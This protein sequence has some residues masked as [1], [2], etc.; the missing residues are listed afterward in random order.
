MLARLPSDSGE[1]NPTGVYG[2]RTAPTSATIAKGKGSYSQRFACL[3]P[4][5]RAQGIATRVR[6]LWI[7]GRFWAP[8]FP[9][10]RLFIPKRILLAWPQFQVG[11]EWLGV[12][13][14]FGALTV[15]PDQAPRGFAN[16]AES[17]F[18]AVGH[19]AVDFA[20]ETAGCANGHCDLSRFVLAD[21]GMFDSRDDLFASLPLFQHTLRGRALEWI[22]GG[23]K[24][25]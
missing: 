21:A 11:G 3:E 23:R 15:L 14:L 22:Y 2:K 17:L 6:G 24:S 20:G 13:T 5:A 25:V 12:E 1:R 4:L 8:R 9:F 16:D 18:D 10:T 7:A 19:S